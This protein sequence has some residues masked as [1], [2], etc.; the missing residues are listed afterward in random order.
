VTNI[1][2]ISPTTLYEREPLVRAG[3]LCALYIVGESIVDPLTLPLILFMH[4]KL[5]GG[6]V[7]MNTEITNGKYDG[8]N[9]YWILNDGQFKSRI[10]INCAG[11][12]GDFVEQIRINQQSSST[13]TFTIMP[14][15][16]QF[17][18]YLSP[19]SQSSIKSI[20]LPMPTKFTKGIIVYPNLF[21]QI[22]VGPTAK[23]QQD[24]SQAPVKSD[25]TEMLYEKVTELIPTFSR[26]KYEY[27]GSYTGIRPAT[28]FSDYQIHSYNE[29]QWI[30]CG[31]IRSTGLTSSLAIG[32]FVCEKLNDMINIKHQLCCEGYSSERYLHSLEQLKAMFTLTPIGLQPN[33]VVGES[34]LSSIS[35]GN[36]QMSDHIKPSNLQIDCAGD[37]Y[38]IS[39]SLLKLAWT[40][41]ESSSVGSQV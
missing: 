2:E 15:M 36:I 31:G 17:S 30:C 3:A 25:V 1:E 29:L 4:G 8:K 19:T 35:T 13:S 20:L 12:F 18:V 21:H 27:I 7:Q 10:V 28:E 34:K 40:T 37:F 38:D 32:E 11:L 5:L 26:S 6:H 33:I 16:G 22:I 39:H 24:R 14:R 9:K 23:T 41:R